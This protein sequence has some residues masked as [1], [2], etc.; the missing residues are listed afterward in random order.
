MPR[1]NYIPT[2]P[3]QQQPHLQEVID[4]Y[5]G[6][7]PN[8]DWTALFGLNEETEDGGG[9]SVP[10]QDASGDWSGGKCEGFYTWNNLK[11]A[12]RDW[13]AEQASARTAGAGGGRRRSAVRTNITLT[14]SLS[15]THTFLTWQLHRADG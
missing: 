7:I 2:Q 1:I 12:I 13:N 14:H 6:A 11:A 9:C 5:S 4:A 10:V 8:G 3:P 15:H